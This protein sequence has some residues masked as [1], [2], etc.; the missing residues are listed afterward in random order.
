M[1]LSFGS[2]EMRRVGLRPREENFGR[3][4]EAVATKQAVR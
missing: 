1:M 2:H 3:A 4:D